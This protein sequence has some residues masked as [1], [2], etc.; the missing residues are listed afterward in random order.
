MS[1]FRNVNAADW[2]AAQLA[3]CQDCNAP[4][5][6][7]RLRRR[8]RAVQV[9]APIPITLPL[10]TEL[11]P[12]MPRPPPPRPIASRRFIFRGELW[13]LVAWDLVGGH[14]TAA[15]FFPCIGAWVLLRPVLLALPAPAGSPYLD[16]TSKLT[17]N[18]K[19][20]YDYVD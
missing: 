3:I 19:Y 7:A 13:E 18:A 1:M 17:V 12:T 8:V 2:I 16:G 6:C 9:D 4:T 15:T 11:L 5:P 20:A 14:P 10:P